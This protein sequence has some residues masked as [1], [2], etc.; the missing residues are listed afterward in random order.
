MG[1]QESS[2]RLLEKNAQTYVISLIPSNVPFDSLPSVF[3]KFSDNVFSV[4]SDS[5]DMVIGVSY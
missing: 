5:T 3:T 1:K 2:C 4:E